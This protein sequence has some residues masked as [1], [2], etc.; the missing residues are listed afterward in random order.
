MEQRTLER[1]EQM[2]EAPSDRDHALGAYWLLRIGYFVLPVVAGADKFFGWIAEWRE[3]LWPGWTDLFATTGTRFMY[4][5]G[6]VE[7]TAGVLVLL[8]PRIGSFLVAGWLAGIVANLVIVGYTRGAYF[9]I[10]LRDVGL[11]VGA[12][13]LFLLAWAYRP[14]KFVTRARHL[15]AERFR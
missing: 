15:Q 5:V 10:L 12:V 13:A 3:Y 6:V 9:D 4:A 1:F 7:I 11:L 14:V 8:L 2:L